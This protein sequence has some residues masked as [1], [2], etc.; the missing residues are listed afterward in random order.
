MPTC[1]MVFNAYLFDG[2]IVDAF[3]NWSV[4]SKTQT[5]AEQC[6]ILL[7]FPTS[8]TSLCHVCTHPYATHATSTRMEVRALHGKKERVSQPGRPGI[9]DKNERCQAHQC[10]ENMQVPSAGFLSEYLSG[11]LMS[12]ETCMQNMQPAPPNS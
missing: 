7:H 4:V 1:L 2:M 12:S 5:I 10:M 8:Y 11:H 3:K 6:H 9:R